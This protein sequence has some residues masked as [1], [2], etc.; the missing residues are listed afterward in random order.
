MRQR[1]LRTDHGGAYVHLIKAVPGIQGA[2]FNGLPGKTARHIDQTINTAQ[3]RR[4]LSKCR[5]GRL[6]GRQ[7]DTAQT[8]QILRIEQGS[9]DLGAIQQGHPGAA[10][11]QAFTKGTA[12]GTKATGDDYPL[13]QQ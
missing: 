11:Q 7:V 1:R 13:V 12:E 3:L 6:G 4:D 8:Q 5:A 10:C 2:T 9:R